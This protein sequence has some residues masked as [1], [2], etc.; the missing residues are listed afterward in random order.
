MMN[1]T[2][3]RYASFVFLIVG[4]L[5]AA[6][7]R[8]I[9]KTAYGSNVGPDIF[10]MGLGI[11]LILLSIRLF[12]ETLRYPKGESEKYALDYK[13]FF[14][15]LAG[16]L[17]YALLL[18]TFGYILMTFLFLF[19]GFQTM[20]KGKWIKS[21]IIAAAFSLGVYY[22]YVVVLEGSLPGYPVWFS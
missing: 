18:E 5:F 12:F 20:E 6:G 22:L 17:A 19:I 10:P 7:S 9:S 11:I 3:D 15:I 1:R 4:I 21:F 2:F 14:I 13:K 8:T 16:A